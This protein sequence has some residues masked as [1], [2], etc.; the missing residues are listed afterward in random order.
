MNRVLQTINSLIYFN[1]FLFSMNVNSSTDVIEGLTLKAQSLTKSLLQ[2][3]RGF[4]LVDLNYK[5]TDLFE[6]SYLPINLETRDNSIELESISIEQSKILHDILSQIL[7]TKGY[8]KLLLNLL[9]DE[10]YSS[11]KINKNTNHILKFY[12]NPYN[13]WGIKIEGYHL[14]LSF[15]IKNKELS[16]INLFLGQNTDFLNN[17]GL[18]YSNIY[19]YVKH[20]SNLMDALSPK[21]MQ[22]AYLGISQPAD[23]MNKPNH[24]NIHLKERSLNSDKLRKKQI[25][26]LKNWMNDYLDL[27]NPKIINIQKELLE[28][29]KYE[30]INFSWS[31]SFDEDE[32]K[33]YYI[34]S[35]NIF[36]E[37]NLRFPHLHNIVRIQFD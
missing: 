37:Y 31:G 34:F 10:K 36:I 30:G 11:L 3:D 7:S 24:Y 12:G 15:F 1:L 21:Q 17:K 4:Q 23:I 16:F 35:D 13:D 19:G 27:I 25:V 28:E 26:F 8:S 9:I 18:N 5:D 2:S 29:R 20:G 14:S 33:Y 22:K 6:N 32:S